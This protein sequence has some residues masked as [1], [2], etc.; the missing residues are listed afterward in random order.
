MTAEVI[1]DERMGPMPDGDLRLIPIDE[2]TESPWNP[3][4][5]F[6]PAAMA[7]LT[8]SMRTNGFRDW[9]PLLV[10]GRPASKGFE[11]GAGHRRSRAARAAGI[12]MIPCIV[13]E[14]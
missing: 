8:D 12:T 9:L 4:K 13:R 6:P 2:L 3:R 7:E 11:I 10:R 5:H 14:M 1:S